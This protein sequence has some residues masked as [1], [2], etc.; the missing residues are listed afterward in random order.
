MPLPVRLKDIIEAM[1]PLSDEWQAYI[2]RKTGEIVAFSEEE[3]ALAE[4]EDGDAPE[5]LKET[6]PTT[7]EAL[8]SEDYV[9]LPGKFELDEYKLMERFCLSLASTPLRERLLAAIRGRG[10]FGRF[11][12]A[13]QEAG[14]EQAWFAY[15][16][17][18]L[19]EL[20]VQFLEDEGIPYVED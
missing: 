15:R 20:A 6:L 19:K 13:I 8:S 17:Q 10:A 11:K 2:N 18:A 12:R 14:I 16:E 9:Q 1:E 3:A 7:R 4:Q 5:W